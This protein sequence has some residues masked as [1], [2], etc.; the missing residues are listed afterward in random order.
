M[1]LPLIDPS[2]V[3]QPAGFVAEKILKLGQSSMRA[4][5]RQWRNPTD[6]E[7]P[8]E[9]TPPEELLHDFRVELR[10][11]R[12]WVHQ[13]R[14]LVR[15]RRQAR[16]DLR[17]FAQATNPTRDL[18]VILTLLEAWHATRQP[19][20]EHPSALITEVL[21]RLDRAA[22]PMDHLTLT[23]LAPRPRK[24]KHPVFG[25]WLSVQLGAQ[26]Q[27]IRYLTQQTDAE[28]HQ[29]RIHVKHLRYLIEPLAGFPVAAALITLLKNM[30]T[31]LGSLHDLAVFR[32]TVPELVQAPVAQALRTVLEVS[33]RQTVDIKRVFAAQREE[34][35]DVVRWQTDRYQSIIKD[36][37]R[38]R[39]AQMQRLDEQLD[40]LCR[41]L[42]P[43][44]K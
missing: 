33:G 4:A 25:E 14:T 6:A 26:Q 5:L 1:S 22:Y 30:Q 17:H 35:L 40:Q 28:L 8:G 38:T 15:T 27:M 32:Q 41:E 36:W 34:T 11:L 29:A 21:E 42:V 12:V 13:T 37:Q 16:L 23:G 19:V 43:T 31:Q 44:K 7:Q 2:D 10:R 18:E 9:P 24:G 39:D 20:P 3:A